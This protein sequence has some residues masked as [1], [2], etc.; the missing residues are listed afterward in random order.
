MVEIVVVTCDMRVDVS[1]FDYALLVRMCRIMF[2]GI[3]A[4]C[5][6]VSWRELVRC[7]SQY[8]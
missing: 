6:C 7:S 4:E 8:C 3:V 2:C 1:V 5:G